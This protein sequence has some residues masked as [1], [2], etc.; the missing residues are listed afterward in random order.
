MGYERYV[1]YA[2]DVPMYFV[3]RGDTYYDVTG[4]SF[5]D[6][7]QGRL[8]GLP[9]ERATS[10][11][12]ANH[13]S[14]I[15]PEVRLKRFLEM[16]GSDAGSTAMLVAQPALWVGLIYDDAAQKAAAALVRGWTVQDIRALRDA[17][18]RQAL[19]ASI[20]G[21]TV[22]EVAR[23]MVAIAR[24]GLRARGLG[25]EVYLAPLD[26]IV[27]SGLTQA[28]RLLH[29]YKRAWGGDARQALLAAEV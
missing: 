22:R 4:Q 24:D 13:L 7:L 17:V 25:E 1:D 10:S 9:G 16:R 27:A 8:P 20:R 19:E 3:K 2:L 14:T 5:R 15:F 28:D 11:D 29:L 21:R 26:E 18:P 6:L 23:D 12:W